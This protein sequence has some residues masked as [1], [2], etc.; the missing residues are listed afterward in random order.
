MTKM[1][2]CR[3][4]LLLWEGRTGNVF[5][6]SSVWKRG[7]YADSTTFLPFKRTYYIVLAELLPNVIWQVVSHIVSHL[8]QRR[9]YWKKD[10]ISFSFIN[11]RLPLHY[12]VPSN[13]LIF[14]YLCTNMRTT[15]RVQI[16]I[17]GEV[18][19]HNDSQLP[20]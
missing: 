6:V 5:C 14:E 17:V 4:R 3:C 8:S 12:A 7:F 9:S 13:F 18:K 19:V 1:Y 10:D 20:R 15:I 16:C 2:K 11:Y